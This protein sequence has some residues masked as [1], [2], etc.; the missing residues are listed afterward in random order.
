[1]SQSVR[2]HDVRDWQEYE[3]FKREHHDEFVFSR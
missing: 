1:M 2:H 3:T